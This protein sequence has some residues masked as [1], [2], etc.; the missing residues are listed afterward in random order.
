MKNVFRSKLR[1]WFRIR[2]Q[3]PWFQP[4]Y[5]KKWYSRTNL[6][7]RGKLW[8][9]ILPAWGH[10]LFLFYWH[11]PTMHFWQKI[12]TFTMRFMHFSWNF[13]KCMHFA[14]ENWLTMHFAYMH[15]ILCLNQDPLEQFLA[16]YFLNWNQPH[17]HCTVRTRNY[18]FVFIGQV[19]LKFRCIKIFD[20]Q[21]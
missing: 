11:F 2:H 20:F 16:Q 19:F 6:F 1:R 21:T 14:W 13:E 15:C 18:D 17:Q 4:T 3:N 5:T 9:A 10:L 12:L 8:P 7:S